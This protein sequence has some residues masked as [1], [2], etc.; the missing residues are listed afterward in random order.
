LSRQI[1]HPQVYEYIK[2]LQNSAFRF[3]D[4][5][6][7]KPPHDKVKKLIEDS[8]NEYTLK[9]DSFPDDLEAFLDIGK[10]KKPYRK[11]QHIML[12]L[13]ENQIA[14]DKLNTLIDKV[15]K[16]ITNIED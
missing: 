14:E 11:P 12:K 9:I 4:A 1:Q 15:E 6:N 3:I 2:F 13:K 16:L 7:K 10:S 8:K 5:N